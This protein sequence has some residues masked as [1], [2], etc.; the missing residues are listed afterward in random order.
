[1][2]WYIRE[3]F[4]VWKDN[5]PY[6]RMQMWGQ[7]V[8]MMLCGLWRWVCWGGCIE[9]SVEG[10]LYSVEGGMWVSLCVNM[11][12]GSNGF[13]KPTTFGFQEE[14]FFWESVQ[15]F[16]LLCWE[17]EECFCSL[18]IQW[19]FILFEFAQKIRN[20]CCSFFASVDL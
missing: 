9:G 10:D 15:Y 20:V 16:R 11:N 14:K 1:M 5:S 6:T 17:N 7:G 18:E 12:K 8:V 19:N 2:L 4:V 3:M 13:E